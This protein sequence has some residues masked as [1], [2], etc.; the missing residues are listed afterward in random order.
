MTQVTLYAIQD[1]TT[2]NIINYKNVKFYTSRRQA[3]EA[4]R[5]IARDNLTIVNSTFAREADWI[6]T[7]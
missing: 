1:K 6:K 5:V 4:K 2:G 7:R 3:R